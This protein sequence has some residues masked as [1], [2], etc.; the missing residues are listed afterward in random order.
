MRN[1]LKSN[2]DLLTLMCLQ[3]LR[4]RL[5]VVVAVFVTLL[6]SINIYA[7][8]KIS[9]AS[10]P[11][12]PDQRLQSLLDKS[13]E[14]PSLNGL[15]KSKKISIALVDITDIN[16]PKLAH[17]NGENTLYA[18]SLPK[19]GIL[20]A[21]FEEIHQGNL[22]MSSKLS[23]LLESMIKNS[24]NTDATTLYNLVGAQRINEILRSDRYKFYDEETG[25]GLWV[26]KPYAKGA[27][28]KRD[29]LMNISH[30]ASSLQVARFYYL[31]ERNELTDPNYCPIMKKILSNSSINHKFVKGLKARQPEAAIY[32]KSGTWRDY[33]S[34]S[35]LIERSDGVTYI[36]V[37]LSQAKNGSKLLENI[38]VDLDKIIDAFHS[39]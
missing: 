11:G 8:D 15:V 2:V 10:F 35:A 20:L 39:S 23:A 16:N 21:V 6:I 13:I 3:Y 9:A 28:W 1:V 25:G 34:D 4:P 17:I 30:G 22:K 5:C 12:E 19:L 14:K 32:R 38:I 37:A 31:L 24:S 33:H 27:A 36:A 7:D 26:G 18:A 29:P